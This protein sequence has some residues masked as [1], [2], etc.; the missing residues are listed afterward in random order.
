MAMLH[1]TAKCFGG[2]TPDDNRRC[3][4]L[5]GLRLCL[6]PAKGHVTAL[7][8]WF[9]LGPDGAH[10]G[11]IIVSPAAA[12]FECHAERLKLGLTPS[13]TQAKHQPPIG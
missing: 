8:A 4:L 5:H 10:G 1:G 9:L 13:H 3:G 12:V 2:T 11:E 7:V 6:D